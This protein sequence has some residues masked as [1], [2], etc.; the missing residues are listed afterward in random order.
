MKEIKAAAIQFEPHKGETQKNIEE[1]ESLI[2]KAAG[3]GVKLMVFPEMATT[4]Y[5]WKD[6][7]EIMNYL[8]SIPGN[9]TDRI[10]NLTK[11]HEIYVVI[12]MGEKSENDIYYNSAV[13]IGPEGIIGKYRKVHPY[14]AD[15]LWASNGDMGINVFETE[16]GN[17][18]IAICMDLAIPETTRVL[19]RKQCDI[20]CAPVNWFG[21][22]LP[23]TIWITRAIETGCDL[24][25][26]NRWGQEGETEFGASSCIVD[27]NGDIKIEK[28]KM[29]SI[30]E[31]TIKIK[32]DKV[33]DEKLSVYKELS[34]NP[35]CW[36]PIDF[37]NQ[38]NEDDNRKAFSVST[39]Q[40]MTDSNRNIEDN[41][42]FLKK[43]INDEIKKDSKLIV[44]PENSITG[45][46]LN[47][48]KSYLR[49]ARIE[50]TIS[51]ISAEL[52]DQYVVLSG[53]EEVEDRCI[54]QIWVICSNG[55]IC[56]REYVKHK[57]KDDGEIIDSID[58]VDTS[59][60]KLGILFGHEIKDMEKT[61]IL[62]IKGVDIIIVVDS[63]TED[64]AREYKEHNVLWS[65]PKVRAEENNTYLVYSNYCHGEE[66]GY[67]GIFG[68]Q[69]F[70]D[71]NN[72]S[73]IIC[74]KPG[75]AVRVLDMN[76]YGGGYPSSPQKYKPLLHLR[77]PM[78]YHSLI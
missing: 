56:T 66:S 52:E 23:S 22:G 58:I 73:V 64:I 27:S 78:F 62:A 71:E 76:V 57:D 47:D 13:L 35:Y 12:G 68:P 18:G 77:N 37:F 3:K 49:R 29:N 63:S 19:Q 41:I 60:G 21:E 33:V 9:T 6:R 11:K 2:V 67:S 43:T 48:E 4:G 30:V 59:I 1:I 51:V 7:N 15:P 65:L 31:K 69:A 70:E 28:N 32:N 46:P 36:N 39:I 8:D 72:E 10:Y 55:L 40:M 5:I 26:A 14:M 44:F 16:I 54:H 45:L 20:I 42:R 38:V 17:I 34:L 74:D 50:K 61:R 25:I 53:I 24:I 75:S